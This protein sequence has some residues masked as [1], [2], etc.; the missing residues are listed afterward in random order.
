[1][2]VMDLAEAHVRALDWLGSQQG[3][4]LVEVVNVGTGRGVSV[5]EAVKAFEA[6]SGES[7][8]YQ[9]GPRRRGDIVQLW[10]DTPKAA[11]VLG[12]KATRGVQDAMADA[13]R[14]QQTLEKPGE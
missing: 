9:V 7:L 8:N 10:A 14:W 3:D 13:W 4:S 6:A 2:H 1:I 11:R 5:L 12:W